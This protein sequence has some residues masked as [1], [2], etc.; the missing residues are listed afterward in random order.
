[1]QK[2]SPRGNPASSK[3][4]R[5]QPLPE[6]FITWQLEARRAMLDSIVNGGMPRRHP[7]HLPSVRRT[8][9]G[10]TLVFLLLI[11]F[12]SD[13]LP[14]HDGDVLPAHHLIHIRFYNNALGVRAPQIRF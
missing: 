3:D 2:M 5:T 7:A 14:R 13:K 4:I 12:F 1:M 10:S 6:D 11:K 9:Y 8:F